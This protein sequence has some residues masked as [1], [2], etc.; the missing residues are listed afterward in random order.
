MMKMKTNYDVVA[1]KEFAV[2]TGLHCESSA[3]MNALAY[4]GVNLSE[5]M[6]TGL[7]SAPAF[8]FKTDDAFPFLGERS[9]TML[10]DFCTSTGIRVESASP[11]TRQE[12]Y[13]AVKDVLKQGIPVALRVNMRYLPYLHGGQYGDKYTSFG[14]HYVCLVG[15]DEPRGIASVTD[16]AFSVLQEVKLT[17]LAR[18][19][20]AKE[21]MFRTENFYYYFIQPSSVAI[22]SRSA[23][24]RSI[25]TLI[26]N[27]E[28]PGAGLNALEKL[29]DDIMNIEKGRKVFILQPLFYTFYGYI[30]EFGTGG[31]GFRNFLKKY[32]YEMA[33]ILGIGD[34]KKT[35]AIVD[36]ACAEWTALALS[37]KN[38]SET[39][40]SKDGA[41]RTM[42]YQNTADIARRLFV[43]EK[44]IYDAIKSVHADI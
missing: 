4:Q 12:A 38:I 16:T 22:D 1:L 29:P 23:F 44:N 27:Y 43:A 30:E 25:K 6:I 33:E 7:G 39:I 42:M 11:K 10:E 31:A 19:R 17:D 34:L 26:G 41:E 13:D 24:Q 40:K 20:A 2:K 3:M 8:F 5:S 14:W 21:G 35:A 36:N 15:I 32:Y 28:A 9:H 18:A 37:F